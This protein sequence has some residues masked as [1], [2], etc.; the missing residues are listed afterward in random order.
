MQGRSQPGADGGVGTLAAMKLAHVLGIAGRA[1]VGI[2]LVI[3]AF[4]AYQ[5]FGTNLTESHSQQ[6]LRQQFS[7]ELRSAARRPAATT[8]TLRGTGG[9]TGPGAAGAATAPP[10]GNALAVIEI[11]S[12]G[13]DKIV[14][15]GVAESD[16]RRG[17]G[18]YPSTPL[19]GQHGNVAIAGHRT[20]YG[21]PF[22]NLNELSAGDQIYLRTKQGTFDYSYERQFVV[23]PDATW[24]VSPT[25]DN[26][27]TLTTCNP[28]YSASQRLIVVAALRGTVVPASPPATTPP[29]TGTRGDAATASAQGGTSA[30]LGGNIGSWAGAAGWGAGLLAAC[31]LM[32]LAARVAGERAKRWRWLVYAAGTPAFLALLYLFFR[33]VSVLLPASI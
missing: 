4:V 8:P 3:L 28:R 24:V 32:W 26:R 31:V 5:L 19:P 27:L 20:T 7:T 29:A 17:P 22:Y 18:H 33:N 30:D 1:L 2:G 6:T 9:S 14:V 12:I 11:P 15:Q 23:S 21:A 10:P 13:V 25:H 16:L